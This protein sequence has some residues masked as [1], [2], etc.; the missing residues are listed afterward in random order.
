MTS[1]TNRGKVAEGLFQKELVKKEAAVAGF[2]FER[3]YDA[4]SARGAMANPRSG[5]FCLYFKGMNILVE[6]KEV[7]HAFRLPRQNFER[8]QRARMKKRELAGSKCFVVIYHST[9][10]TWRLLPLSFFGFEDTGSWDVQD[11]PFQTPK[12]IVEA[13]CQAIP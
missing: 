7:A 10:E 1:S 11:V 13:L 9:T 8:G 3:I 2:T 5:D 4:H 12:T 6:I